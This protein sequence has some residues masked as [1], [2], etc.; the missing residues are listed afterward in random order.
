[1]QVKEEGDVVC[2]ARGALAANRARVVSEYVQRKNEAEI[3]RQRAHGDL[4]G[5]VSDENNSKKQ[6]AV[7]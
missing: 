5:R 4:Y 2:R 3:N 6:Y 7:G 1:M